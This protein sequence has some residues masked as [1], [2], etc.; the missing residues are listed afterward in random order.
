M[1]CT[2]GHRVR[3]VLTLA[4]RIA[5]KLDTTG[6][7]CWEWKGRRHP[8]GY[9][10]LDIRLPDGSRSFP[11]HVTRLVWELEHGPI[12]D[13][14][15]VCHHCD[16]PP[17]CRLS[18]LFLGTAKENRHDAQRKGR[19][20]GKS[21]PGESHPSVRLTEQQVLEMRRIR[22]DEGLSLKKLGNLFGVSVTHAHKIVT[23]QSWRHLREEI[24]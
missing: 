14:L 8:Q 10:E 18:H 22:R 3:T 16:N 17:C 23:G 6:D 19:L 12:P 13:G 24:A 7:G 5:A 11:R 2:T 21:R 4:E 15:C 9:G 1:R 20:R